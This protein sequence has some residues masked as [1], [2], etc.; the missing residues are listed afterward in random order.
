MIFR[1]SSRLRSSGRRSSGLRSSGL[2]PA[3][4]LAAMLGL[5]PGVPQTAP[6]AEAAQRPAKP[7][8]TAPAPRRPA[9]PATPPAAPAPP[10]APDIVINPCDYFDP[11]EVAPLVGADASQTT[12]PS[13][14]AFVSCGYTS[15]TGDAVTI[16]VSD[17]GLGEVAQQFFDRG[18]DALKT[19]V[20]DETYGVPAFSHRAAEAPFHVT[21]GALKGTRTVTLEAD[22]PLAT[23]PQAAPHLRA[24]L[25][26]AI[27]MLPAPEPAPAAPPQ[28]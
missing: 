3:V 28:D 24:I 7:S 10:A 2:S 5:L 20:V 8:T 16:S 14:G 25:T 13:R 27:A 6:Q 9:A 23:S 21:L 1:R 12:A 17:Y 19:A 18:R 22:G 15:A 26:K 11:A 4:M